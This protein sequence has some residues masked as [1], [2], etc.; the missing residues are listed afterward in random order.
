MASARRVA[1]QTHLQPPEPPSIL[2][3][4]PGHC[5]SAS[6]DPPRSIGEVRVSVTSAKPTVVSDL[7]QSGSLRVL[8]PRTDDASRQAV[9]VNTAGGITGGDDLAVSATL[10]EGSSLTVTT[11]AAERAYRSLEERPGRVRNRLTVGAGAHIS[12]LPQETI[13]FEGCNLCR[14]LDVELERDASAVVVEPLVF[15]RTAMGEVLTRVRFSDRISVLR[16]GKMIY[17]DRIALAGNLSRN[18]LR[19]GIAHGA[20]AGASLVFI[21]PTAEAKLAPMRALLNGRS[22]ASLMR[23]E[24]L[25]AR[26]LANDGLELRM[27]LVR[28]LERLLEC[29]IPKPWNL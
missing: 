16:A 7:R 11:Q 4:L 12:W 18:L 26:I 22:G 24:L 14:T 5:L 29:S 25:A 17:H 3:Q 1:I 21:S 13:L 8:F 9:I 6:Q 15:G 19:P 10:D 23:N 20:G 28:V 27:M 2:D